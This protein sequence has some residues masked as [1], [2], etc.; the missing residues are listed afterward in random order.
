MSELSINSANGMQPDVLDKVWI[1]FSACAVAIFFVWLDSTCM[2]SMLPTF[3]A[4]WPQESS[5]H[6]AWV[7]NA[8]TMVFA[9][10]LVPMGWMV[11][12]WGSQRMLHS[13]LMAYGLTS[14]VCA[15]APNL[16][17]LI[18]ARAFQ[19]AAAACLTPAALA[20]ALH[21]LPVERHARAMYLWAAV[22]GLAAA[23]GPVIAHVA[24]VTTWSWV[25]GI[26]VIASF[27]A[28]FVIRRLSKRLTARS[29]PRQQQP[30]ISMAVFKNKEFI[31]LQA[32]TLVFGAAFVLILTNVQQMMIH[33]LDM[34]HQQ[35]ALYLAGAIMC[36]VITSFALAFSAVGQKRKLLVTV[37]YGLCAVAGCMFSLLNKQFLQAMLLVPIALFGMGL[38]M[39][40]PNLPSLSIHSLSPALSGMANA[41][42]QSIR[43]LGSALG[44][45]SVPLILNPHDA[46]GFVLATCCLISALFLLCTANMKH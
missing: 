42:N 46:L 2:P 17:T 4:Q 45:A 30:N 41:I 16:S 1:N 24:H 11:D 15:V 31:L 29:M 21:H 43:H 34:T 19:G 44:I 28:W 22:G 27:A 20:W 40:L 33:E 9:V 36:C 8:Y 38:G 37:G 14:I 7:L 10:L 39:V 3:Y 13:G 25:F 23:L 18:I 26:H 5:R 6:V 35:A 32:S 12:R